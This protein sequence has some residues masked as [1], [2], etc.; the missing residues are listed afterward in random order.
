MSLLWGAAA[1]AGAF[2]ILLYLEHRRPLRRSVEPK[3]WRTGRN[4]VVFGL[5][6]ATLQ[7][8]EIPLVR[9]LA[10]RVEAEGWG[11]LFQIPLPFWLRFVLA[12]L[13]LDYML[14]I[15]HWL[16]HRVPFLWRFHLVHHV[17]LDLD[18]ST[19]LRFHFAE[20]ALSVPYRLAQVALI[21]GPAA[22]LLFWQ[23]AIVFSILF[24]H[25]NV[26]LSPRWER[27]LAFVLVTPRMHAIHHSNIREETDSN[28]S[29]LVPWWDRLHGTLRLDVPQ[30]EITIGVPAYSE[31]KQ[32]TLPRILKLPFVRQL[33]SWRFPDGNTN[34]ARQK[35][36]RNL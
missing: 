26:S 8:L 15:W 29:S 28:W 17:D 18:A 10:Q 21:G 4:L 9:P 11:L 33:D 6:A 36:G 1:V 14:Y 2:S 3:V 20:M 13:L 16:V 22:A 7:W 12:V 32:V 24:H 30:R 35:R 25:S 23:H 31:P 27:Y 19:A 5:S 34:F